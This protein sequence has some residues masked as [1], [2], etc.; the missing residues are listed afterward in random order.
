MCMG[1]DWWL[2]VVGKPV[3]SKF[4]GQWERKKGGWHVSLQLSIVLQLQRSLSE[5]AYIGCWMRVRGACVYGLG[6]G[7][8]SSA[9]A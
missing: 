1:W 7:V 6:D 8:A 4:S 9:C 2:P 5:V 3:A